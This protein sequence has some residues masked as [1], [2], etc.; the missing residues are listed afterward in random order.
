MPQ[1]WL[2]KN[3]PADLFWEVIYVI[4]YKQKQGLVNSNE[5][6]NSLSLYYPALIK[7]MEAFCLI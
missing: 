2:R 7:H 4:D 5:E 1:L 3:V 6:I